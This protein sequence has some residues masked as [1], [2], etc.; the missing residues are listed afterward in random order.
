MLRFVAACLLAATT[1]A[2]S[3]VKMSPVNGDTVIRSAP[4]C[5]ELSLETIFL[6]VNL[7]Y[8]FGGM[9]HEIAVID[10]GDGTETWVDM[11]RG[12][13][14]HTY[15]AEGTYTII[16]TP[17]SG[18]SGWNSIVADVYVAPELPLHAESQGEDWIELATTDALELDK[19][20]RST[21]DWGDGSPLQEFEWASGE[22]GVLCTPRHDYAGPGEYA[23]QVDL[24][25]R[26]STVG[27]CYEREATFQ[28][29]IGTPTPVHTSTWGGIKA[30]YQ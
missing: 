24:E 8:R 17:H 4:P 22:G 6:C 3:P 7:T 29:A 1:L 27:S 11:G 13:D 30:L 16:M 10:W 14:P 15:A 28:A 20:L 12:T 26:S 5:P 2:A 25:Y 23:I 18:C 9:S 19:L 21:V